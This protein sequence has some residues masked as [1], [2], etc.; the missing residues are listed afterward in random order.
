[1]KNKNVII[2]SLLI[3]LILALIIAV[4]YL[5][6]STKEKEAEIA[7]VVE[8]MNF[9][10]QQVEREFQDMATEFDGYT[11]NIKND[12]LFKLLNDQKVKMHQLL[13]ELRVTKSTNAR[14]IAELKNELASVRKLLVHYVNQIDALNAEN[15]ELKTENSEVKRRYSEASE[16]VNQLSK[17]KESLN[18]VVTRASK[19]EVSGFSFTP[20][21]NR[22]KKT[23]W[24]SQIANLQF[25]YTVTK[26][27]TANPGN[28]TIYVRLTR[29]DSEVLTKNA[30]QVFQF[31]NKKI[32]YS[33]KKDFEY[34]GET[35][36]DV[37]YW[38]VEEVLQAGN[39]RAEFFCDGNMVG[40]FSFVIKK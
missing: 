37:V 32:N 5:I 24:F 28:K 22:N 39:Y 8:M 3:A 29:P 16:T 34:T 10:K 1:M 20:L 25:N 23:T 19:L 12:S 11:S 35:Y 7:E 21:N 14:K 4:I 26:N 6:N 38:K 13:E 27:I 17:E 30:N 36:T 2:Y 31:E 18:E 33:L 15:K 9:E 40:S